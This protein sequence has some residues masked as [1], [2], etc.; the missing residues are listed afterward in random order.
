[1]KRTLVM[2]LGLLS[3]FS[4]AACNMD[5]GDDSGSEETEVNNETLAEKKALYARIVGTSWENW[6]YDPD[7]NNNK[8]GIIEISFAED[9][10]TIDGTQISLNQN[11]DLYFYDELDKNL[12]RI[13]DSVLHI[14]L[15]EK[16]LCLSGYLIDSNYPYNDKMF[17]IY[18][19]YKLNN[20][21]LYVH[22]DFKLISSSGKTS[23]NS[24]SEL[25]G[26]YAFNSA[27][28]NQSKG[29]ITLKDGAWS[30]SGGKSNVAASS[31]TY[32]VN[33]SEITMKWTATTELE[34]TFTVSSSGSS[35]TW[36]SEESGVSTFFSMLFG[37]TSAKMT[38]DYSD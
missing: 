35:S 26:T 31:G 20:E 16:V 29:S 32:T 18:Q 12:L 5:S 15:G 24:A 33:G 36:I 30:Y 37:V 27:S 34:E 4:F 28:G 23:G 19:N 38:F 21:D 10:V 8:V 3:L 2:V 17:T 11:K 13:K 1:M 9:S 25:N 14:K 6:F 22:D 7:N